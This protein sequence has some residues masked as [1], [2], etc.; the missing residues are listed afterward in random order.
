MGVNLFE[1]VF[2]DENYFVISSKK[3]GFDLIRMN[4]SHFRPEVYGMDDEA[5]LKFV[6]N[7]IFLFYSWFQIRRIFV[8]KWKTKLK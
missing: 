1:C 3:T 4:R 2:Q 5:A 7:I 8:L 6:A